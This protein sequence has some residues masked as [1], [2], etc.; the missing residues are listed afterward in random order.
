MVD[1]ELRSYLP[2]RAQPNHLQRLMEA[3][4]QSECHGETR[5]SHVLQSIA[6]RIRGRGVVILISDCFDDLE[7][8]VRSLS[9]FRLDHSEVVVF[10]IWDRDELEFPFRQRVEFRNLEF[11]DQRKMIEPAG[12]RRVYLERVAKFRSDLSR[13]CARNRIDLVSCVTDQS[14]AEVLASYIASRGRP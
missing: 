1:D 12:L 5:L 14:H 13:L 3:L 7:G 9:L 8:L 4:V 6:P 11:L 2:P 10:Q